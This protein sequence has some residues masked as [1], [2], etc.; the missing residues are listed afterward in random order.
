MHST[1]MH[2]SNSINRWI[3]ESRTYNIHYLKN[4]NNKPSEDYNNIQEAI[5]HA[6]NILK[7]IVLPFIKPINDI[8]KTYLSL[9]DFFNDG[10]N[11]Q[12]YKLFGDVNKLTYF[13]S[14]RTLRGLNIHNFY[15]PG[16]IIIPNKISDEL[17]EMQI[18]HSFTKYQIINVHTQK[19]Y[20]N[21]NVYRNEKL[22]V[23]LD[24]NF[25][26]LTI[27]MTDIYEKV[28]IRLWTRSPRVVVTLS[29]YRLY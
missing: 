6:D 13:D 28:V 2:S 29:C 27:W 12:T 10:V 20:V 15:K 1:I 24:E 25:N 8:V 26:G 14:F 19:H 9:I 11:V 3:E 7:N 16:L 22:E 21:M 5:N 23:N 17:Y 18:P 4:F